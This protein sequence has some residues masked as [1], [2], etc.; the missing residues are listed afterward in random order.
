MRLPEWLRRL[1]NPDRYDPDEL[2]PGE[3]RNLPGE[4]T[5]H[6]ITDRGRFLSDAVADARARG[7][8]GRWLAARLSDGK[9]DGVIYDSRDDAIRHQLHETQCAYLVVPPGPMPPAEATA[10]L[11]L[12]ERL[13]DAGMR[14]TDPDL[15]NGRMLVGGPA[16][17]AALNRAAR[18]ATARGRAPVPSQHHHRRRAPR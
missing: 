17:A 14:M 2:M 6:P 1:V 18:R 7:G 15:A 16:G 9:T 3:Y 12:Q 13:Y 11:S 4:P 8:Q 5:A 10:W